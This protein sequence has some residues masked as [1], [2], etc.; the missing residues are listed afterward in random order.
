MS[1]RCRQLVL[2][3]VSLS[4][5][6][7]SRV[8]PRLRQLIIEFPDEPRRGEVTRFCREHGVSRAEFYKVKALARER[9]RPK[10]DRKSVV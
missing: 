4:V 3:W 8:S 9:G 6:M 5:G 2:V 1:H 10:S 7:A